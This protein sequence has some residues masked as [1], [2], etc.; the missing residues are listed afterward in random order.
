[1]PCATFKGH[2]PSSRFLLI[3]VAL[4]LGATLSPE[5]AKAQFV[6]VGNAT[7]ALVPL[8]TADG[9]GATAA[10]STSNFACGTSADASG[11]FSS[12][13]ATG[14]TANA[15]GDFSSNTATGHTT[16]ASGAGSSNTA[17]G[18]T[19]NASGF[20]SANTATGVSANASGDLSV[21][22]ATGGS[23]NASGGTVVN[24]S[25]NWAGGALSNASGTGSFNTA[26]GSSAL[27]FGDGSNNVAIG[28]AANA[29][30]TGTTNTAVGGSSVA[31]GTNST[32]IG[33][34]AN[35]TFS[36][37]SAFG[38]NATVTRADQMVLGTTG[39]TYTAPGITS[40]ASLAAQSG[41][42]QVV[43]SDASGNL[44]TAEFVF[45]SAPIFDELDALAGELAGVADQIAGLDERADEIEMG[46]A[47]AMAL[48]DPDLAGAES[49]GIKLNYGNFE[50]ADALGLTAAGVLARDVLGGRNRVT[51]SGG[52]GWGLE[53]ST[54]GGRVGAQLTW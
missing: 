42:V 33:Q 14:F 6:C 10:G 9:D 8:A 4:A 16:D 53:K 7:G 31:T 43:T 19:A 36:N 46:V 17:T 44:G 23:A 20:I 52:I 11:G 2:A 51:L 1:M 34:S 41:P 47:I 30:G 38:G 21:N 49:F 28:N 40:A 22:T 3:V 32:A 35:A 18:N 12:N 37:S 27:A 50:G 29:S 26:T 25:Q 54:V 15:S 48:E 39:N 45:D 24:P 13:T 5:P